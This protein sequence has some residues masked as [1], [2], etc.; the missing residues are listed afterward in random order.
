MDAPLEH[1]LRAL[2]KVFLEENEKLNLSAMRTEERAWAGHVLDSISLLNI[3]PYLKEKLGTQKLN[4]IVDIGTGGG[5]PLLPLAIALP[6][7]QCIGIDSTGKKLKAIDRIC[8]ALGIKNVQTIQ[9]RAEDLA[10][11]QKH[12]E[13][14]DVVTARAVADIRVLL[15]LTSP[16][17]RVNGCVVLWK[18]LNI[19]GEMKNA[20]DAEKILNLRFIERHTYTLPEDFGTR[21][22]LVYQKISKTSKEYPR[23][24]GEPKKNPL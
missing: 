19:E 18:S 12:R 20:E 22:L 16:F 2:L 10:H 23:K 17:L 13:Q 7:T 5:F 4:S 21:Q 8:E 9:G 15:E 14:Y 3:I 24:N 11:D 6:E 1:R